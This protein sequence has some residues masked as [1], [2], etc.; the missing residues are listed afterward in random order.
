MYI[1]LLLVSLVI[2]FSIL[3]VFKDLEDGMNGA[4]GEYFNWKWERKGNA[5]GK[6]ERTVN[7]T[8]DI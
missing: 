3:L 7:N 6:G 5:E 8:K 4:N 1:V 2:E